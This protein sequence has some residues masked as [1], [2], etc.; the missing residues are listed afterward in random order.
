MMRTKT[1]LSVPVCSRI[2]GTNKGNQLPPCLSRHHRQQVM[3]GSCL[4]H[5]DTMHER[6]N[7][8]PPMLA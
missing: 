6:I 1:C 8:Q 5:S 4:A 2:S 7:A 3:P